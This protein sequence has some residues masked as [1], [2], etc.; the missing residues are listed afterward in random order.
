MFSLKYINVA[1][2]TILKNVAN[3]LTASEETYFFKKQH[4]TQVWVALMLM[5]PSERTEK[6]DCQLPSNPK[7]VEALRKGYSLQP[8]DSVHI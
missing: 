1:M 6:E 4:D 2:L 7:E 3:V 8:F 5:S